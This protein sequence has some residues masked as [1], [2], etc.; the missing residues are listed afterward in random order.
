MTPPLARPHHKSQR[1]KA[2]L[3]NAVKLATKISHA[4]VLTFSCEL[5]IEAEI[6]SDLGLGGFPP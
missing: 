2:A 3:Y 5:G 6:G 1:T 4:T